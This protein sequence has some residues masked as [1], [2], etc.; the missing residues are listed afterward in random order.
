MLFWIWVEK[1]WIIFW[2]WSSVGVGLGVDEGDVGSGG[3]CELDTE[4]LYVFVEMDG[5]DGGLDSFLESDANI[6][7]WF[8]DCSWLMGRFAGV[9]DLGPFR[10]D[11]MVFKSLFALFDGMIESNLI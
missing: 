5:I 11:L 3:N 7:N 10:S 2:N 1:D 9:I 6:S 4:S 8:L